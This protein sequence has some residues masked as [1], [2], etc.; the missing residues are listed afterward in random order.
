[1]VG[2]LLSYWEGLFSGAVLVSGRVTVHPKSSTFQ[3]PLSERPSRLGARKRSPESSVGVRRLNKM[4]KLTHP[5]VEL[6]NIGKLYETHG[7]EGF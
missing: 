2:I 1:M 4:K 5:N 6:E 7:F 3:P